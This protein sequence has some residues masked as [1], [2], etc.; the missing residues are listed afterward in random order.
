MTRKKSDALKVLTANHLLTGDVVFLHDDGVWRP[1][2][3]GARLAANP[4]AWDALELEASAPATEAETVGACLIDVTRDAA[5]CLW[6]VRY[7]EQLRILGPSILDASSG[8]QSSNIGVPNVP[9]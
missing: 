1:T 2:L 8:L 9:V 4:A 7:R 5:G 6:P 3:E